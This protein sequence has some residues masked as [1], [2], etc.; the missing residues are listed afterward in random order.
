[1]NGGGP[2]PT[3]QV[4]GQMAEA[5]P[6]SVHSTAGSARD[7][8]PID[9]Q[10]FWSGTRPDEK[11]TFKPILPA[12]RQGGIFAGGKVGK[13]LL[14]LD[15]S[16]AAATGKPVLGQA[17]SSPITVVYLDLEMTEDDLW[18][19]LEGLGYGPQDDLSRLIYYSLPNLP[20]LDTRHGGE[21]LTGIVAECD[22]TVVVLDTMSR[23]VVGEENSADTVRNFYRH[24][25]RPLKEAGVAL[26]RLDH[27]GRRETQS[28][29]GSSAKDD[30]LDVV[31]R[32]SKVDAHLFRLTRTRSRVPWVPAE[33]M[34]R[35]DEDPVLRH[36][37]VHDAVPAGTAEIAQ[38]LDEL[39][40]PL[41]VTADAALTSLRREGRGRR[42]KDVLAA[43]NFRRD[44][45]G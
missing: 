7:L 31:F 45:N 16:A 42:R 34:L 44:R 22:A 38:R 14:A 40:V 28:A 18:E 9:W 12:G 25:G 1:M 11:W 41:D 39:G 26:L 29:R 5:R 19:R 13:S 3:D 2:V 24:T 37:L 4:N 36:H 8:V 30:D 23:V 21:V 35:R 6:S 32:Q 20:P 27:E 15:M 33:V 43:I 17:A 10:A